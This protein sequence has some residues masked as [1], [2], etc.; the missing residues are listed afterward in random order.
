MPTATFARYAHRIRHVPQIPRAQVLDHLRDA[1]MLVLPSLFEGSAVVLAEALGAGLPIVQTEA[2]GVGAED[3]V[4]GRVLT[5]AD[6]SA[7]ALAEVLD[8]AAR[9]PDALA[10]YRAAAWRAGRRRRWADYRAALRT[11]LSA[12]LREVGPE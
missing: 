5:D 1:D 8:T 11:A 10:A 4:S 7:E 2:A 9:D 12:A 6:L 3:G